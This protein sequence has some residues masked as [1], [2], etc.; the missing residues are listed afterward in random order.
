M[1]GCDG[2]HSSTR[3]MLKLSF[4]G[5]AYPQIFNLVD[6][7]IEWPYSR[8]KF[9]FFL[10]RQGIFV[11]IP[12]TERIS[13]IML[14]KR[15]DNAEE[16]LST[17]N[18]TALENLAS[19]LTKVPVKF[20]NPIWMSTF[21]LHHRGVNRY[22]Q[23]RVFLAGDAAHIHSPLGGQGMN[24]GI[25]DSTNLA[26]KLALVLKKNTSVKLL[27]T[28]ET[29]RHAVGKI[30]LKTTDQ[31]FSLLTA[32][33]FLISKLRNGL[34]PWLIKFLFSKKNI[35][36]RLFWFISQL[37]I[38]YAK[39]Q[40]NYEIIDKSYSSFKGGVCPG[41]RAPNAPANASDL[42]TLL[43]EKPFNILYFKV[44]KG[45]ESNS[46]GKMI[47]LTKKYKQW[48]QVHIFVLSLT[49]KLLF[50]RYGVISSSIYVIRPDGYVGFRINSDNYSLLCDYLKNF[51]K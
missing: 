38:H 30:L 21:R 9:F 28:Y 40:F 47:S 4:E 5:N 20:T 26:W 27:S 33:G 41:H 1:I 8:D 50:E 48:L 24:T 12:L 44:S 18:L 35:E 32:S 17:P 45:L 6:A 15:S 2:A 34:L 42:F 14:A 13:R 11:H 25:Q 23:N 7:M 36:N 29:E 3:H 46:I 10:G 43:A 37:N 49:N 22:Y 51:F 39:N 31:F 19:L 16:K